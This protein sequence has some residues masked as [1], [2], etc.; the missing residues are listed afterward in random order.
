MKKALNT[1]EIEKKVKELN[2]FDSF[3]PMQGKALAAGI[4]SKN[5]VLGAPTASGKTIIAA[6]AAL[7][8]IVNRKRKVIFTCPLKAL[9]SEHFREFKKL[10]SKEF[11]VRIA[12]ST[13]DLDS[14][15]KYL[16]KYDLIFCTNEKIDSLTR[17]GAEWL[18]SVGLL[19]S[20]EIHELDSD[21]GAT[22]EMVIAKMRHI[23]PELQVLALS[24]TIPNAKEIAEWLDATLVESDFRP[25]EL[26]EGIL[27]DKTIYF[28]KDEKELDSKEEEA[29]D[30]LIE[31]TL[32]RGKQAMFFLNTRRNAENFAKKA[33]QTVWKRL[34]PREKEFL[35]GVAEKAENVLESPTE[36]C[37]SLAKLL[38][39]GVAF[40]HAGLLG[41]QRELVEDFFR[42]GKIKIICATPTLAAGVNLP[43]FRVV[44]PSLYR[45]TEYGMQRIPVR[46]YK[47]MAGRAGRPKFDSSGESII[48]ARSDTELDE[49]KECY[50][51]GEIERIESKLSYEPVLRMHL[52]ALI[53]SRFVFDED[54]MEKFF[55]R[56]FYSHQFGDIDGLMEKLSSI[57]DELE[58]YGFI[59]EKKGMLF[60]TP[61]GKR[62]SDLYL[63]PV[64]AKKLIEALKK[65]LGIFAALY[66]LTDTSEFLPA[67]PAQ[68]KREAELWQQLYSM[69]ESLP[70]NVSSEQ[71]QDTALLDKFNSAL[72]LQ[73]WIDE[74]SEQ[75]LMDEFG[76]KPGTLFSKLQICDWLAYSSLEL[77]KLVGAQENVPVLLEAR[78]RLKYGVKKELLELVELR[79]I[80][81]VRGRRLYRSGMRSLPD[82]K[83]APFSDVARVLGEAVAASVK[84]QLG[85]GE[86]L[87]KIIKGKSEGKKE[88][89]KAGQSSLGSFG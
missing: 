60:A 53:A 37:R 74:K 66:A 51:E 61:L 78:K 30:A 40:H 49:L 63:D 44:I 88:K 54:S 39:K 50:V 41:K 52:L 3:N 57:S 77:A 83:R 69:Q 18:Q 48:F 9:A 71:F 68:K 67:F 85:Q 21:R 35:K 15:S 75:Q 17:H 62:V 81:R 22:L 28:P 23:L 76:T 10:Y 72:L 34:L 5:L 31:D 80:G 6:L 25:V 65:K 73:D 11:D 14:S 2:K 1:A 8:C 56:T 82:L 43:S 20:D 55:K 84:E 4:Y 46:E 29:L 79:G 45:Y 33:S 86:G 89:K 16:S 12:I 38:E 70:I 27:L 24:A 26:K 47:Q 7:N 32:S 58:D 13:G 36:Q 64:S 59:E 42:E 19:I 87:P